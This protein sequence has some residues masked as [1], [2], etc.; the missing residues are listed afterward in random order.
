MVKTDRIIAF[1]LI[2]LCFISVLSGYFFKESLRAPETT[3]ETEESSFSWTESG[4]GLNAGN[5]AVLDVSGPIMYGTE[6]GFSA[7]NA[8][9]NQLISSLE[10]IRKDK[11]KGILIR[12]NSPGGTASASQAVYEKIMSIKKSDNI[13]VVSFMQDVA[14]SGAYY[15]ASASDVIYANPTTLTGSIG[16]IMQIPNFTELSNKIGL[17]TVTIKSGKYKDIGN[18]S[19]KMTA[20]EQKLLQDMIND[21]YNEFVKAVTRGRNL[22][23]ATVRQL[24]DGRIYTGNQAHANK[25]IDKVG[26]QDDAVKELAKLMDLKAEPKLKNYTKPS[27]E[28]FFGDIGVKMPL[29]DTFISSPELSPRFHK[30]PLMLY[31]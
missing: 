14:A 15:I 5:I 17:Q 19:R 24:G 29:S 25:L 7:S 23:E 8:D 13:K 18:G 3:G 2:A 11:M 10:K 31:K 26:Q 9:A 22:P 12:L 30:I 20:D 16:V 4:L 28:K 1:A 21:T 6:G 27:W